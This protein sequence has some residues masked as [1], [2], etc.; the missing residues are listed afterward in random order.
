VPTLYALIEERRLRRAA[1][2]PDSK[3]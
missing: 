3:V 2:A 1:Q